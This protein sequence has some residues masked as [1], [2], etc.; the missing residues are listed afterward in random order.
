MLDSLQAVMYNKRRKEGYYEITQSKNNPGLRSR[1]VG[2]DHEEGSR[3][4]E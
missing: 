2:M 1:L 4:K 3:N